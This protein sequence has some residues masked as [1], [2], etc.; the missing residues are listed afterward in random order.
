M[1]DRSQSLTNREPADAI[2]F[3]FLG[4][5]IF[6]VSGAGLIL[7]FVNIPD[8]N[9]PIFASL[10]SG[11]IVGTLGLYAGYRYGSSRGSAA[12]DGVISDMKG[13]ADNG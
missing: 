5:I 1:A 12:K 2:D 7:A 8:K 13:S 3:M 9:L 4:A 6:W 10:V 11:G